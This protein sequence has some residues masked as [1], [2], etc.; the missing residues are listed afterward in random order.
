MRSWRESASEDIAFA[1][2][3]TG[4]RYML[5]RRPGSGSEARA[6]L[7]KKSKMMI[8]LKS[9]YPLQ[10]SLQSSVQCFLGASNCPNFHSTPLLYFFGSARCFWPLYISTRNARIFW[11]V[12]TSSSL[13]GLVVPQ[14]SCPLEFGGMMIITVGCSFSLLQNSTCNFWCWCVFGAIESGPVG[15]AKLF[16]PGF[17]RS[18]LVRRG[19]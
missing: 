6:C 19:S 10:S 12:I 16:S 7:V 4:A 17:C 15:F 18:L 8:L 13:L 1:A 5:M 2:A 9:W 11:N 14:I 3:R